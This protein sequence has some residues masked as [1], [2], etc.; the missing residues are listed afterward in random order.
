M[1]AQSTS[2]LTSL[3]AVLDGR[4]RFAELELEN[5]RALAKQAFDH[6]GLTLDFTKF[7]GE[8]AVKYRDNV[9]GAMSDLIRAYAALRGN[10]LQYL[11][12]IASADRAAQ[13]A[14]LDYYRVAMASAELGMKVDLTNTETD[15]R[16]A[17][18]AAQFIGQSVGHH[19]QAASA[20]AEVFARI[21][22]MSLSGLNGVASVAASV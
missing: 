1:E 2:E 5:N 22:G 3:R 14:V 21:A 16:W 20:A 15:L 10:E 6:L 18:I 17:G 4:L 9:M 19:V 12:G 7:S 8:L 13:A 11:E